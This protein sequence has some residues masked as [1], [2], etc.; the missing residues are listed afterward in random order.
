MDGVF[1][2]FVE[3]LKVD[4]ALV[5]RLRVSIILEIINLL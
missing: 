2:A 1:E 3:N 4:S 5:L